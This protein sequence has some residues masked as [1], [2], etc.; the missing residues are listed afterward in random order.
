MERLNVKARMQDEVN[1]LFPD[2]SRAPAQHRQI[3][4]QH[5]LG[6]L[7]SMTIFAPTNRDGDVAQLVEQ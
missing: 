1:D 2:T 3:F 7:N 5:F 4:F 6:S